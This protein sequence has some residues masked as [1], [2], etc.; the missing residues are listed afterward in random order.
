MDR[1]Y[2][3]NVKEAARLMGR[4][5]AELFSRGIMLKPWNY[6]ATSSRSSYRTARQADSSSY[7][8]R[9][10]SSLLAESPL[11]SLSAF[12]AQTSNRFLPRIPRPG[13]LGP[14]RGRYPLP[15][16]LAVSEH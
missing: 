1:S 7:S 8:S 15:H 9:K 6:E 5:A 10:S 13:Q 12:C 2:L 4:L 11:E 16:S 14:E 3:L